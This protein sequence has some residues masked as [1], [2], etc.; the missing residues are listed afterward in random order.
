MKYL[1]STLFLFLFSVTIGYSQ[2]LIAYPENAEFKSEGKVVVSDSDGNIYFGAD[3]YNQI[4]MFGLTFTANGYSG[5]FNTKDFIIGKI[6]SSG[7]LLWI[8]SFGGTGNDEISDMIISPNNELT[9]VGNFTSQISFDGN[10]FNGGDYESFYVVNLD[11]IYGNY[12]D[13]IASSAPQNTQA[14][15]AINRLIYDDEGSLYLSGK[16]YGQISFLNEILDAGSQSS[17]FLIK[18]TSLKNYA[19]E[20]LIKGYENDG[21]SINYN[22]ETQQIYQVGL[23]KGSFSVQDLSL[24][25]YHNGHNTFLLSVNK[26]GRVEWVQSLQSDGEIHCYAVTSNQGYVY[27]GGELLKNLFLP[28]GDEILTR[29]YNDGALVGFT[30]NGEYAYHTIIGGDREDKI[31]RLKYQKNAVV[32]QFQIGDNAYCNTFDLAFDG[33]K[34]DA[35]IT[36]DYTLSNVYNYNYIPVV[37]GS[38][39]VFPA[40]FSLYNNQVINIGKSVNGMYID[41]QIYGSAPNFRDVYIVTDDFMIPSDLPVAPV[42]NLNSRFDQKKSSQIVLYPNPVMKGQQ[43]FINKESFINKVEIFDEYGKYIK[44]IEFNLNSEFSTNN[45]SSGLYLIKLYHL[46]QL[47]EV[48]KLIIY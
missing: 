19:W 25:Q 3:F 47:I 6:N 10:V 38:G 37:N 42:I 31:Y 12:I 29:G 7:D 30:H 44:K 18:L 9:I 41:G 36:L 23:F 39:Q 35:K 8:K 14:T 46:N 15:S 34:S 26:D 13:G 27:I 4:S 43:V 48:K 22:A 1:Y 17:S 33:F 20:V 32:V 16:F 28:N 5:T 11:L 21:F 40:D 2:T 24:T 45:L